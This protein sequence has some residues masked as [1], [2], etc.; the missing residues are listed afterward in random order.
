MNGAHTGTQVS[1]FEPETGYLLSEKYI[2]PLA[3]N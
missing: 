1:R 2:W 3:D